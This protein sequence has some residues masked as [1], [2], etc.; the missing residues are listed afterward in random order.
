[1]PLLRPFLVYTSLLVFLLGWCSSFQ[2]PTDTATALE[3]WEEAKKQGNMDSLLFYQNI[4]QKQWQAVKNSQQLQEHNRQLLSYVLNNEQLDGA[5]KKQLL[6]QYSSSR[7]WNY[8]FRIHWHSQYGARD[9][10]YFYQ[11][12]LE[13]LPQKKPALLYAYGQLAIN[14]G[15]EEVNYRAA[16]H[17]LHQAEIITQTSPDSQLLYPTQI[18]VYAA[19]G[20][21]ERATRAAKSLLYQYQQEEKVDSI[22]IA[23]VLSQLSQLCQEQ[24]NYRKATAYTGE[25]INYLADRA[26][27]EEVIGQLWQQLA[28]AYYHL[29]NKPLETI[30]YA[31]T[32]L[33]KWQESKEVTPTAYLETY[34]LLA[35]QFLRVEQLDS[36]QTYLKKAQALPQQTAHQ[37]A[38]SY[39]IQAAIFESSGQPLAAN[40]ALQKA[41]EVT[42]AK[43]GK[44]GKRVAA[45]WLAL[46]QYYQQQKQWAAARQALTEAFWALS[47]KRKKRSFPPASSLVD[48]EM[49]LLIGNAQGKVL[50]AL[51]EQS[52]YAVS[53]EVLE[54]QLQYNLLLLEELQLLQPWQKALWKQAKQ[55]RQQWIEWQWRRFNK[56]SNA[57]FLELAFEQVEA[58]RQ[59]AVREQLQYH[60][61]QNPAL[62]VVQL[63]QKLQE[64]QALKQWYQQQIWKA[65]QQQDSSQLD[66]YR[67]QLATQK[68]NW[69]L[70][71]Q[72]LKEEHQQYYQW[73]YQSTSFS[74]DSLQNQLQSGEALLEYLEDESI[75]YQFIVTKDTLVLRR[76]IW[77]EYSSTVLKYGKHFTNPKLRQYLASGSF[78]DFCRTGHSLYYR[79]VH[80]DLFKKVER[81]IIIPDGLLQ[82][83]PFETLLTE[84]PLDSIHKAD[85][86]RLDYLLKSKH[87]HYHYSSQLW[88]QSWH[89]K[90]PAPNNELLALGA[91]Y[92]VDKPAN[93]AAAQQEFRKQ[94]PQQLYIEALIDSLSEHYAGDFYNNRYASEYYYKEYASNYGL[95]YLGFYANNGWV[96]QGLP[97]LV[98]AEDGYEQEDNFLSFYEIQ[99]QPI[100]AD[101]VVLGNIHQTGVQDL[102]TLGSSFLYAGSKGVVLP[103]WQQDSTAVQV[104]R[105][106]YEGLQSGLKNDEALRQAKLQYLQ[107]AEGEAGHPSYWAGY[108]LIGNQQVVKVAAPI[109]YIWWFVIPIAFISFLGWWSLQAL[110][111]RR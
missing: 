43:E 78:Q 68:A 29:E 48:K 102:M 18:Q 24:G 90:P 81:L 40:T 35:R 91:T 20:Q 47:W 71:K 89:P 31:R 42:L 65:Y 30:L 25:A 100:Q 1:M 96:N 9:S 94:L 36:S 46:G 79:L 95:L 50:L 19:T 75:V 15:L 22:A 88:W 84:I 61:K 51:Q 26:G 104:V 64:Q 11:G 111:Q 33:S 93:R 109:T 2:Y 87:I 66:W 58:N 8:A 67:Q 21:P 16:L 101:L 63:Q 80:H 72:Q 110:R 99:A 77:E 52:R 107:E 82:Q 103:L 76:V 49:A 74:L 3:H 73:Y 27:Q 37:V 38:E 85:F 17:Y 23:A 14:F 12:L 56:T 13:N 59:A 98:V 97:S 44:K 45:H 32:A 39:A 28:Q 105:Y 57:S 69:T 7:A 34:Q 5:Q 54:E 55:A 83:L 108:V 41:L 60:W 4:L 106:Y 6:E 62:A 10:A 53:Q 86:T 92:A 70:A